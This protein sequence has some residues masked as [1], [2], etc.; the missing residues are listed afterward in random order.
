MHCCCSSCES[1]IDKLCIPLW[2]FQ[3][4]KLGPTQGAKHSLS[5]PDSHPW[6][7]LT[8]SWRLVK[9]RF[10]CGFAAHSQCS[11][12]LSRCASIAELA[13]ALPLLLRPDIG[14][15]GSRSPGVTEHMQTEELP[16]D[17]AVALTIPA[18]K[19]TRGRAHWTL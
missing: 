19:Q 9:L 11:G 18:R 13:S 6:V 1:L 14:R 3:E 15:L 2:R 7:G 12:C 10:R 8:R 17:A 16:S 4:S 5:W